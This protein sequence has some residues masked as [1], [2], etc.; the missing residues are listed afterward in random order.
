MHPSRGLVSPADFIGLAEETGLIIP[1]G[2]WV[3]QEACE[4]LVRWCNDPVMSGLSLAVNVSA[5]QFHSRDFVDQV[6]GVLDLTRANPHRLK[7][8]LTES[9]L[10]TNL[11]EIVLKMNALKRLG[12][13]F[14]LD[15]FGT[16]YSSLAYLRSLPIDELKI[17]QSFVRD[18]LADPNDAAIARTVVAL[19]QSLGL[20]VIAEGVE[21]AE[22]R[23]FLARNGCKLFQGYFFGRPLPCS[24]FEA[25]LARRT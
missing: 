7:L 14:S 18:V 6:I 10:V 2:K 3:I 1:L 22:H 17:D 13:S 19:G 24:E 9:L 8:E 23:D 25:L 15:D 16:G 5:R 21:T 20:E 11:E 12:I 4:Q